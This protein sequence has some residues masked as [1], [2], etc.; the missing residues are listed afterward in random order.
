MSQYKIAPFYINSYN[1]VG[2]IDYSP[3]GKDQ[4]R[5][6][7]VD[8]NQRS[9]DNQATLPAFFS[10]SPV[11]AYVTSVSYLHEF[12]PTLLNEARF[13]YTRYFSDYPVGA[14]QFPGLDQFPN[15]RYAS[16]SETSGSCLLR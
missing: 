14:F 5:F 4:F 13:A 10:N 3:S 11:N 1:Y 7:F 9:I 6:R 12:S 16:N 15:L 8:N 2:N